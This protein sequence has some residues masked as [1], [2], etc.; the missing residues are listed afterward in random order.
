MKLANKQAVRVTCLVLEIWHY[1][2]KIIY[3]SLEQVND[4]LRVKFLK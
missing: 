2:Y 3:K 4:Y 1:I